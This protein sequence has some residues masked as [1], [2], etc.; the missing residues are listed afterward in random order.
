MDP[1]D[2]ANVNDNGTVGDAPPDI[3]PA[4]KEQLGMKLTSA[5][6]PIPVLVIDRMQPPS[7]N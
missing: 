6:G 1:E 3:A 2:H 5:R 4:P 7:D